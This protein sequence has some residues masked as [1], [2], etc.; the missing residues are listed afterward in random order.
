MT[1]KNHHTPLSALPGLTNEQI[2]SLHAR[3]IWTVEDFYG[4]AQTLPDDSLAGSDRCADVLGPDVCGGLSSAHVPVRQMGFSISNAERQATLQACRQRLSEKAGHPLGSNLSLHGADKCPASVRLTDRMQPI[5]NQG[6]RGTCS[7]FASVAICEFAHGGKVS[8]SPQ[9]LYWACKERD[10]NP[11]SDGTS[12]AT[13]QESLD[14]AGVC[15]DRLW[16]YRSTP[17]YG[18]DGLLDAGQGPAPKGAEGNACGYRR[19]C[20][21][22]SPN[23]AAKYRRVLAS[24]RPVVVGLMT[25]KSWT[26]NPVTEVTGRVFMPHMAETENGL[27]IC[28]EGGGGHAMCLVGYVD[29][30]T[31]PGGGYFIARNSWGTD[32]ASECAEG[33]GHALIPYRYVEW[34]TVSAFTVSESD[35]GVRL[36]EADHD[37]T[38]ASNSVLAQVPAKLVPYTQVLTCHV[39]D[40]NGILL[41]P[42]TVVQSLG[43]GGA[44]YGQT[45]WNVKAPGYVNILSDATYPLLTENEVGAHLSRQQDFCNKID[46]NFSPRNLLRRAFPYTPTSWHVLPENVGPGIRKVELWDDFSDDL[47]RAMVADLVESN[48]NLVEPSQSWMNQ[49]KTLT[50]GKIWRVTSATLIPRRV[51]VVEA[52]A[53]PFALNAKSECVGPADATAQLLRVVRASVRR[54]LAGMT[55]DVFYAIGTGCRAGNG[56]VAPEEGPDF[57]YVALSSPD[58]NGGW[59][60]SRSVCLK[61][62]PSY[63][64]FSDRL[65]PITE[66]E[67]LSEVRKIVDPLVRSPGTFQSGVAFVR[68][69]IIPELRKRYPGFPDMRQTAVVGALR[70]MRGENPQAYAIMQ[71]AKREVFVAPPPG[72]VIAGDRPYRKLSWFARFMLYYFFYVICWVAGIGCTYYYKFCV[73]DAG[74]T[75]VLSF[76]VVPT[77]LSIVI[78]G[79]VRRIAVVERN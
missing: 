20:Q 49:M 65:M 1:L 63:R 64:D 26:R 70:Q 48:P 14:E 55:G 66:S 69:D 67:L 43:A 33:A 6:E 76:L 59:M 54:C 56:F 50:V 62:R 57:D 11:H 42:G 22:L 19:Q 5:R 17:R 30:E 39:R 75:G 79:I 61:M 18:D 60:V 77:V 52:F 53:V 35:E 72:G 31:A 71:N 13:V 28:E 45:D 25:F 21:A 40:F 68:R 10:G 27:E 44:I 34:F 78:R 4:Y 73:K 36:A 23:A 37:V 12:L 46:A 2:L 9:F 16:E 47:L 51:Y 58:G 74:W 7:A 32:W 8:L 3:W 15:E 24:G 29:E 41:R 38:S